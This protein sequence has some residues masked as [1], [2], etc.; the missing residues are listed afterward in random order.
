MKAPKA[1]LGEG[2]GSLPKRT[3]EKAIRWECVDLAEFR[4][5]S[6]MEK[7]AMEADTQKVVHGSAGF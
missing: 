2:L 6:V 3:Y 4:P 5:K 7:W 1:W